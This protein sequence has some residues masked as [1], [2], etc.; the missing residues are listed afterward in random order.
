VV[1]KTSLLNYFCYSFCTG[2]G[3]EIAYSSLTSEKKKKE[4]IDIYITQWIFFTLVNISKSRLFLKIHIWHIQVLAA[5]K[6][7]IEHF[8][9]LLARTEFQF[10]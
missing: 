7:Y 1:R 8:L 3:T 4:F 5:K 6:K 2:S 9:P 10:I